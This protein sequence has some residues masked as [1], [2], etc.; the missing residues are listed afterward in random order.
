MITHI[1][2]CSPP[3]HSIFDTK[4]ASNDHTE[5]LS[6]IRARAAALWQAATD[7][8]PLPVV[9]G[10][11]ADAAETADLLRALFAKTKETL[12]RSIWEDGQGDDNNRD[13]NNGDD[14]LSIPEDM[15]A[16]ANE[17]GESIRRM[18]VA[19]HG[20]ANRGMQVEVS[21]AQWAMMVNEQAAVAEL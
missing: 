9:L 5:H 12:P 13:S 21:E 7:G 8:V 15:A 17:S 20:H 6:S 1:Q 10:G 11:T 2:T 19:G 18:L 14:P 4:P 3:P 16:W